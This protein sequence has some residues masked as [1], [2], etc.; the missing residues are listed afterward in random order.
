MHS[1]TN[2]QDTHLLSGNA[3]IHN[4]QSEEDTPFLSDSSD[5]SD[6]IEQN[7]LDFF[8]EKTITVHD[9]RHEQYITSKINEFNDNNTDTFVIRSCKMVKI[10]DILTSYEIITH[11]EIKNTGLE[12]VTKL[13]PNVVYLSLDKNKLSHIDKCV[14]PKSTKFLDLSSNELCSIDFVDE[15]LNELIVNH[16]QLSQL[17][18]NLSTITNLSAIGNNLITLDNLQVLPLMTILKISRNNKLESIDCLATKMPNLRI[19]ET[20]ACAF[21][22]VSALPNSLVKWISNNGCISSIGFSEFPPYLEDLDLYRN[23][24]EYCPPL[25]SNIKTVDLMNNMLKKIVTFHANINTLDLR[26]NCDMEIPPN[27]NTFIKYMNQKESK[28]LIDTGSDSDSDNDIPMCSLIQR[29]NTINA[30]YFNRGYPNNIP[31]ASRV[32]MRIPIPN[33]PAK[34]REFGPQIEL[35]HTYVV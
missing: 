34:I 17:E 2:V 3:L 6:S 26:L 28:V 5:S 21:N 13:P 33:V 27:I 19:L 14:I 31:Y 1:I 22:Q 15:G 35:K 20:C 23:E 7:H 8:K 11:L 12:V 25:H 29:N 24:L 10:P 9:I 18:G 16:N 32:S 30:S 4:T